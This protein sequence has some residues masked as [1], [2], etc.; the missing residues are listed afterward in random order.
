LKGDIGLKKILFLSVVLFVLTSCNSN[1]VLLPNKNIKEII[2]VRVDDGDIFYINK[3]EHIEVFRHALSEV[4]KINGKGKLL[5]Q[6]YEL[7]FIFDD[8]K[9]KTI[10]MW[11]S[12]DAG[13]VM[14]P[15]EEDVLFGLSR[16][17]VKSILTI[18]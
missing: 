9:S 2:M 1:T 5:K 7:T 6:D 8:E 10:Y 15:S 12:D 17:N 13:M 18:F 4:D 3:P 14:D 16:E 11:L